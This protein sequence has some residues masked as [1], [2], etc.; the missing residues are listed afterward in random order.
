MLDLL[1]IDQNEEEE[2]K[3]SMEW[4]L[5]LKQTQHTINRVL[6]LK[7]GVTM[8]DNRIAIIARGHLPNMRE[9]IGSLILYFLISKG[10]D[11]KWNATF[12]TTS[13]QIIW[14][15]IHP[16]YLDHMQRCGDTLVV[17]QDTA[18][19][20]PFEVYS[21]STSFKRKDNMYN[22]YQVHWKHFFPE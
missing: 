9:N 7:C 20:E 4:V 1:K 3:K 10:P 12:D 14:P 15:T 2:S 18:P 19:D 5:D 11:G 22:K 8:A 13:I 6:S 17:T 21:V 16:R